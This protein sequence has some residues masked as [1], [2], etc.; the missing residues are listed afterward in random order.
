[1]K[2]TNETVLLNQSVATK[3]EAIRLAGELLVKAGFVS[4][5]YVDAML[6]REKLVSTYMG[7]FLAIPHGTDEAKKHILNSGISLVQVPAGVEFGNGDKPAKVI[8]G[9]AGKGD[10]HLEVLSTVAI[11]FSEIEVAEQI[12]NA[13]NV[14]EINAVLEGVE[15]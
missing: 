4:P 7:N 1:M 3:E 14:D 12:I 5:E 10:D 9:I 2:L 11:A 6:E 8:I 15:L 13:S